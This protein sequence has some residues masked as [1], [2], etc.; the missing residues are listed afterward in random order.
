MNGSIHPLTI[1]ERKAVNFFDSLGFEVVEGEEITTTWYNFDS[2]RMPKWHPARDAQ[3]TFYT[4][5]GKVLRTHTSAMQVKAMENRKPP[6]RIIVPGR[7]FRNEATDASHEAN[8]YQLE[9][10]VVDKN[11][12]M[13]HLVGTLKSFVK[14]IYGEK[15][16]VKF[17]PS[18]FPF[19]EPGIEML[20]KFPGNGNWLEML[21]AGM[22]HPEVLKNMGVDPKFYSGFAFGMGMD[23]FTMLA[24]EIPDIR[25][26][27]K[28]DLRFLKQ[29]KNN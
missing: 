7:V 17:V 27:Y 21:G 3:D 20:I 8:L 14:E 12:Q 25:L 5:D 19:V 4:T 11:I 1:F 26:I 24:S 23:R 16:Q 6:V 29:F 13:T 10:F 2:L 9:G 15:T 28:G 18:Y 22:V